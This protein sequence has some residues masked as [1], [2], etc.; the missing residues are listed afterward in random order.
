AEPVPG[1]AVSGSDSVGR[2]RRWVGA[3]L[4]QGVRQ[5][6]GWGAAV[7]ASGMFGLGV[8]GCAGLLMGAV[9]N[10]ELLMTVLAVPVLFLC[11]FAGVWIMDRFDVA[12]GVLG[13]PAVFVPGAMLSA[14]L[15]LLLVS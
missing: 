2:L 7:A 10:G 12:A 11:G 6:V 3:C 5:A 13:R 4:R 1:W 15:F 14:A 9:A 8:V